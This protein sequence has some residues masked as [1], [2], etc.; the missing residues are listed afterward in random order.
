[1]TK[2]LLAIVLAVLVLSGS[3]EI[4][5]LLRFPLLVQH[6][7]QHRN[8]DASLSFIEFIKLHY[9]REEYPNDNDD[10]DDNRLPFKSAGDIS[11]IDVPV[12]EKRVD[13][14]EIFSLEKRPPAYYPESVP[15]HRSFS[16]FHPPRIT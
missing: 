1:M 6:Y 10:N 5:Q 15:D 12:I 13:N 2:K 7:L 8:K 4:Q 11:H 16:I 14:V 3:T 9:A